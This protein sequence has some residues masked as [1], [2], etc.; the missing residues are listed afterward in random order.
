MGRGILERGCLGRGVWGGGS[1]LVF[2]LLCSMHWPDYCDSGF[3][4]FIITS[5]TPSGTTSPSTLVQ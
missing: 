4:V 2:I 3:L 1:H 5:R